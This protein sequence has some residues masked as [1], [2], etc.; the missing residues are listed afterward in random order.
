MYIN[1]LW[2]TPKS[3][4]IC[5]FDQFSLIIIRNGRCLCLAIDHD[6]VAGPN[7]HS[8]FRIDRLCVQTGAGI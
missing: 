6:P 4:E 8:K 3:L 1:K 5:G 2:K 7:S